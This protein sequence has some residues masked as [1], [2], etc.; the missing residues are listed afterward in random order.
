[1]KCPALLLVLGAQEGPGPDMLG[2]GL[3]AWRWRAP[4]TPSDRGLLGAGMPG[5]A[6]CSR[7]ASQS[8]TRNMPVTGDPGWCGE[9]VPPFYVTCQTFSDISGSMRARAKA[10]DQG[11]KGL[12]GSCPTTRKVFCGFG[13]QGLV[14]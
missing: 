13:S 9:A 10:G 6:S 2:L 7:P 14:W 3:F 8:P 4:G 11:L 12:G 5:V 1:M